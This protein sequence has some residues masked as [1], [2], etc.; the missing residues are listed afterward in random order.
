MA[1]LIRRSN[2]MVP[3]TDGLAVEGSWR[4]EAD[5]VTLDLGSGVAGSRK[6]EA[7]SQIPGCIQQA[8]KGGAEVFV[9]VNRAFVQAD[10]EA[11]VAPG[12]SGIV[13][14]G[15][16]TAAEVEELSALLRRLEGSRGLAAGE[17]QIIVLLETA[18][19]I[20]NVREILSCDKRVTQAGIDEGALAA[21]TGIYPDNELDPFVYARGRLAIE[22]TALEV[23]PIGV[24][25]P[26]GVH[27][28]PMGYDEMLKAATDSR[29]LGFKGVFCPDESW[30]APVNEAFTPTEL[31]VEYYTQVREV[32]AQGVAAGT[33]AVPFHGRMIDVPVDE[34]AKV[35]L[36][37]AEG[38]RR[39]YQQKQEALEAAGR[40][41]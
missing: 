24:A 30:V 3:V 29:N 40:A 33:A 2:L 38:C 4:H 39:R 21:S 26:L 10:T 11:A 27:P 25:Y 18:L 37:T 1:P 31:Q 35:V 16:E 13:L 36:E 20:W 15:V 41:E 5:A 12:L 7:R 34:W 28:R 9:R 32:F 6:A 8:A 19:G 23:Q 14:P 22:A 17:L